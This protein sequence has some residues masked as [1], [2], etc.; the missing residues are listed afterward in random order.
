MTVPTKASEVLAAA[1]NLIEPEGAWTRGTFARD[2]HGEPTTSSAP[3]AVCWCAAGA[4]I[5]VSAD[6]VRGKRALD[7]MEGRVGYVDLFNDTSGRTQAEVVAA[8]REASNL[9]KKEGN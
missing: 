5:R 1:A 8:M 9:A 6:R 2:E 7:Y 3:W 4:I